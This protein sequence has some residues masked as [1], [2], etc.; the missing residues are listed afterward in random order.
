MGQFIDLMAWTWWIK[1]NL[2]ISA[3]Q[4]PIILWQSGKCCT[5]TQFISNIILYRQWMLNNIFD[6]NHAICSSSLIDFECKQQIVPHR[7]RSVYNYSCTTTTKRHWG[8]QGG[9]LWQ[10]VTKVLLL[11][12]LL[13]IVTTWRL[14]IATVVYSLWLQCPVVVVYKTKILRPLWTMWD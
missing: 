3:H 8:K 10:R 2:L 5:Y 4:S 6:P 13:R 14:S 12:W 9:G 11:Q 1:V 7:R